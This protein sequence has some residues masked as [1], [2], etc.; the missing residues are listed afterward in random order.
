MGSFLSLLVGK[1]LA[2]SEEPKGEV[3]EHAEV[4]HNACI[5][6]GTLN[7]HEADRE[8]TEEKPPHR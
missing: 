8:D 7:I 3:Q 5:C 1:L 4:D 2:A 6:C